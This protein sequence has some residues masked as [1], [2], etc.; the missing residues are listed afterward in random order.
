M[1]NV[2]SAVENLRQAMVAADQLAL[3]NLTADEL[4]YGHTSGL[5]E[6]KQEF[7]IA[8]TGNAR[9]DEFK[10]IELSNQVLS[11]SGD[12]AIVRHNFKAEV[13]VNGVLIA[14]DIQVLQVWVRNEGAWKLLAR[15][16]YKL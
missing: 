16:S 5:V 12:V 9:R 7:I 14:P 15:Q 8:I 2:A 1:V 3:D 10:W 11:V 4:S 6:N 13:L